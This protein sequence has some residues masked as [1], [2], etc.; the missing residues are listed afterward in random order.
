MKKLSVYEIVDND[1]LQTAVNRPER[2]GFLNFLYTLRAINAPLEQYNLIDHPREFINNKQVAQF[3]DEQGDEAFPLLFV[4]DELTWQGFYPTLDVLAA[5]LKCS[6]L[7]GRL[8]SP[9]AEFFAGD[10]G[11][12]GCAGCS[13]CGDGV[14]F[15]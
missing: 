6:D 5:E 13:G 11:E 12:G 7:L 3:L 14:N 15:R 8:Q 2:M 10:C 9:P 4:D 1:D